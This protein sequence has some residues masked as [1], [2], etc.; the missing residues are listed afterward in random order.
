MKIT[1]K[2]IDSD[3]E[4]WRGWHIIVIAKALLGHS[5]LDFYA[6]FM[7]GI[8]AETIN[9]FADQVN[10]E[11]KTATLC[12]AAPVSAVPVRYFMYTEI[13]DIPNY[14]DDFKKNIIEFIELNRTAIKARKILVDLH[15]DSDPVSYLYL[16]AAEQTFQEYAADA[17][18]DEI[19]LLS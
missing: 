5:A 10:V 1:T 18:I 17:E 15:R 7:H 19:V 16:R 8:D 9:K 3:F 13:V 11:D 2:S 4:Q 12:P 6:R 14:V